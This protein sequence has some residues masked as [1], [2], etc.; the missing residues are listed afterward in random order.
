MGKE[1]EVYASFAHDDEALRDLT[2]GQMVDLI[3]SK[4]DMQVDKGGDV[5]NHPL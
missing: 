3:P 4:R 2:N 1:E 5:P